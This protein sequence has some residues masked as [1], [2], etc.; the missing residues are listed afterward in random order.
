MTIQTI[1]AF[2]GKIQGGL[3]E[4]KHQSRVRNDMYASSRYAKR[5]DI[6]HRMEERRLQR[7]LK[8]IEL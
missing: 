5:L 7:E 8:E 6:D 3:G 1:P 4:T 2:T